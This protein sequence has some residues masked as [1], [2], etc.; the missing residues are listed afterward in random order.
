MK[1]T[2]ITLLEH[3]ARYYFS[4]PYVHGRTLDIACGSGYGTHLIAKECKRQI[5]EIVGVDCDDPSI[6]YAK[7]TYY[8][9]LSSFKL[10]DALDPNLPDQ[11]GL[12]DTILSFETIEHVTD[13]FMFMDN[14]YRM[15]SPGGT[16]VLSTPFGRGR[17]EP[18]HYPFHVQQLAESEFIDLFERFAEIEKYYQRKVT[19]ESMKR[20]G[21]EYPI[22][23]AVCR[24]A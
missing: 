19:I 22:G 20:E 9:P 8:H 13:D 15:L 12:F 16:L 2:D 14:L 21:L 23:I 7:K 10:C 3:L 4:T 24:K 17:G 11:L 6:R 1:P 5:S 18:C